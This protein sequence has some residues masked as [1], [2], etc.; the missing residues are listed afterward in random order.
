MRAPSFRTRPAVRGFDRSAEAYERGRPLYPASAA[1]YLARA[2]RLG[3]RRT[4]VELGS[5]TGKFTRSLVPL[6]CALVAVEPTAGMRRVFA[7]ELPDVVVLPGT[8]EA[9]P[10]PDALADAVVAAQSFQWFRHRAALKEI[11]RILRPGGGLGLVWNVRDESVRWMKEVSRILDR[12]G[13]DSVSR[14]RR[15]KA[16]FRLRNLPFSPLASRCF[17]H[18]QRATPAR[19]LDRFLSVSSIA[20]LPAPERGEVANEIRQLLETDSAT[21]GRSIVELPYSTEVYWARLRS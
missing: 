15:W 10:L 1:R 8:A 17:S 16:A 21:R 7:R 14:E 2:L 5:G 20:V 9:I 11:A 4:V 12:H 3:P 6:G 13:R 19:V 18:V